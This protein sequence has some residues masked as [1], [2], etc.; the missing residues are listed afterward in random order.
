MVNH[1]SK[2]KRKGTKERRKNWFLRTLKQSVARRANCCVANA[3]L[4]RLELIWPISSLKTTKMSKKCIF[5][6]K[7][8]GQ[9]VNLRPSGCSV[10][11]F[12]VSNAILEATSECAA[13]DQYQ[14]VPNWI[15]SLKG[16]EGASIPQGELQPFGRH[17]ENRFNTTTVQ[18]YSG[19]KSKCCQ[20]SQ[21]K[22][23]KLPEKWHAVSMSPS[24]HI[25]PR[26]Q[27][28]TI[29]TQTEAPGMYWATQRNDYYFNNILYSIGLHNTSVDTDLVDMTEQPL[30]Q[31]AQAATFVSAVDNAFYTGHEGWQWDV[32]CRFRVWVW[33]GW[34]QLNW[35]TKTNTF[36]SSV[37]FLFV[38]KRT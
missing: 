25:W 11:I 4:T 21:D 9:W 19:E 22:A 35:W 34:Q 3:F 31:Q 38:K 1:C 10:A 12:Q 20:E 37:K 36:S 26:P 7:L 14:I 33:H 15:A 5:G 29:G 8:R 28:E 23:K 6:K 2:K 27:S 30:E 24:V 16:S 13:R 17:C 32:W 18:C